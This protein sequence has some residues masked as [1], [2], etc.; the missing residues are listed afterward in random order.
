MGCACI[1]VWI[2]H[3]VRGIAP[4]LKE[5][6]RRQRF[7]ESRLVHPK[8]TAQLN[9]NTQQ[10]H[11]TNKLP[12][13]CLRKAQKPKEQK[14]GSRVLCHAVVGCGDPSCVLLIERSGPVRTLKRRRRSNFGLNPQPKRSGFV[15]LFVAVAAVWVCGFSVKVC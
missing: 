1:V 12:V 10:Q 4:L 11:T 7:C 3:R 6:G 15:C 2:C 14:G 9:A 8:I 13:Q 5:G